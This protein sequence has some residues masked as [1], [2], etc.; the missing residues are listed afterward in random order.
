MVSERSSNRE[1]RAAAQSPTDVNFW[2]AAASAAPRAPHQPLRKT[3]RGWKS[4]PPGLR[5]SRSHLSHFTV[6][7]LPHQKLKTDED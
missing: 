5:E 1:V 7:I 3:Q 2:V 4:S 6:P